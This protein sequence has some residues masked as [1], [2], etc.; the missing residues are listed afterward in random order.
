MPE[1]YHSS[2]IGMNPELL[3]K[4]FATDDF[5]RVL[6]DLQYVFTMSYD[7]YGAWSKTT[8][9][10]A[11]MYNDPANPAMIDRF[12]V[13]ES[14]DV[15]LGLWNQKCKATYGP[16]EHKVV[17]GVAAYGRSWTGATTSEKKP[18]LP[19]LYTDVTGSTLDGPG[20]ITDAA[21]IGYGAMDFWDIKTNYIGNP[22][23][24]RYWD[25]VAQ[26]PYLIG[27]RDDKVCCL[28]TEHGNSSVLCASADCKRPGP[29]YIS[30]DDEESIKI[31]S[32]YAKSKG[33][34]GLMFWEGSGDREWDLLNAVYE[35][36]GSS[37]RVSN[38]YRPVDTVPEFCGPEDEIIDGLPQGTG[39]YLHDSWYGD[40]KCADLANSFDTSFTRLSYKDKGS[41]CQEVGN[42]TGGFGTKEQIKDALKAG[43]VGSILCPASIGS[44]SGSYCQA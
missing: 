6:N 11:P 33:F 2:A 18:G 8:G 20:S 30:Y 13:A 19:G 1:M 44:G 26:V 7:F 40:F 23:V 12:S 21:G 24:K 35:G 4:E 3:E 17:M 16:I 42:R 34:A 41:C 38:K 43:S 31:K 5:C 25:D 10:N 9:H 32:Q 36:W 39:C 28:A 29:F 22:G 15:F 14:M 27:E 37:K